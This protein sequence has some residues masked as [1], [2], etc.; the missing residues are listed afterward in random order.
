MQLPW[1]SHDVLDFSRKAKYAGGFQ[2]KMLARS[3]R[4]NRAQVASIS[5]FRTLR[6]V[7]QG[8]AGR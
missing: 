8:C 6:G 7:N 4:E 3:E 1:S 5:G 2:D